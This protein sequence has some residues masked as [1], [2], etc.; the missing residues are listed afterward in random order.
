MDVSELK[1]F[2]YFILAIICASSYFGCKK[3][4][5]ESFID[6]F[7]W[8]GSAVIVLDSFEFTS[9]FLNEYI[10][11]A[12]ICNFIASVGLYIVLVVLI[13]LLGVKIIKLASQFSGSTADKFLGTVFGAL[14]GFLIAVAV[15]GSIYMVLL[16]VN[17]NKK[18]DLPIWM[19]K[20]KGYN[21]LE[22]S[23]NGLFS[24]LTSEEDR[25]NIFKSLEKKSNDLE[26]N[27]VDEV[28]KKNGEVKKSMNSSEYFQD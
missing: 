26:N 19:T 3:G 9:K 11:S 22:N 13:S 6:F 4:F 17:G 14:R 18:K 8:V 20:A 21:V 1:N 7:A 10:P 23:Y 27:T 16:A 5:V 15:F 24:A 25:K 28:S 2:D 12:F